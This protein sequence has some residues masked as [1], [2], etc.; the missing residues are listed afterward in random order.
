MNLEDRPRLGPQSPY[1]QTVRTKVKRMAKIGYSSRSIASTLTNKHGI[2]MSHT[3]VCRIL[4]GGRKPLQWL[5]VGNKR[6]LSGFN[7][8]TRVAFCKE[9]KDKRPHTFDTWVFL[10]AKDLYCYKSKHG[11]LEYALQDVGSKAPPNLGAKQWTP[12]V[13]RFYGAVGRDFKSRMHFVPPSPDPQTPKQ[14]KN[15]ETFKS[16]HF[17]EMMRKL[18]EEI[19]ASTAGRRGGGYKLIMDHA[20]QHFSKTSTSALEQLGVKVVK[21]YPPQSWDLNIIENVWGI[22]QGRMCKKN[23]KSGPQWMKL[24]EAAWASIGMRSVNALHDGFQ[25]R[26]QLV[27]SEGGKWCSHH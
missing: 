1:K 17:I 22:L 20:R 16:Q 6:I 19:S 3:S 18:H 9:W 24:I 7:K 8:K 4:H 15:P 14:K 5:K 2:S 21:G 10:D 27:H 25:A 13:F 26:L 11:M 12:W 23:A